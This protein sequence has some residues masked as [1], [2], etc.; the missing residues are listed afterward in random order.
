M[1]KSIETYLEQKAEAR[2]CGYEFPDFDEWRNPRLARQR[3]ENRILDSRRLG[4]EIDDP[5]WD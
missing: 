4:L 1:D 2:A 3:A 5:Y